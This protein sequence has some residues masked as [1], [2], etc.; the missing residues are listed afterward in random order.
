MSFEKHAWT[1]QYGGVLPIKHHK[2]AANPPIIYRRIALNFRRIALIAE[3]KFGFF[4]FAHAAESQS[5][6]FAVDCTQINLG[7]AVTTAI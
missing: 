2:N 7:I 6:T 4:F 3:A 1:S 5:C